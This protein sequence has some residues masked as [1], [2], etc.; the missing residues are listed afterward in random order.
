[1]SSSAQSSSRDDPSWLCGD[2][3]TAASHVVDNIESMITH[4]TKTILSVLLCFAARF[5]FLCSTSSFDSLIL[6][7]NI[8]AID[9][10]DAGTVSTLT[11]HSSNLSLFTKKPSSSL[12]DAAGALE[13]LPHRSLIW[14]H[15]IVPRVC[16]YWHPIAT[17]RGVGSRYD[18]QI[19]QIKSQ[20]LVEC[21]SNKRWFCHTTS[22]LYS[23]DDD[24]RS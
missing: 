14:P 7:S 11:R 12:D 8:I 17:S 6:T 18:N 21:A 10:L 19:L 4:S 15:P 22:P 1:M 2:P 9:S 20:C 13:G 23:Q 5:L 3:A 24:L 16:P